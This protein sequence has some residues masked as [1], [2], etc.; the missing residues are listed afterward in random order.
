MTEA[1]GRLRTPRRVIRSA[2]VMSAFQ[3][4]EMLP[5]DVEPNAHVAGI[6]ATKL[7]VLGG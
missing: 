4:R 7:E 6:P 2:A 5:K 1:D 3:Y